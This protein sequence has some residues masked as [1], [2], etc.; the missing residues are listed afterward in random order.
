MD[1][2][3]LIF[4]LPSLLFMSILLMVMMVRQVRSGRRRGRL[5]APRLRVDTLLLATYARTHSCRRRR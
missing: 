3:P 1:V 5:V 2:L 4:L